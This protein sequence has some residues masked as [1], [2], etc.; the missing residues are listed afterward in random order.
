MAESSSR[1][2]KVDR[3]AFDDFLRDTLRPKEA[4]FYDSC[5]LEKDGL[6]YRLP[7]E[8]PEFAGLHVLRAGL[9]LGSFKKGRF[10]PSHALALALREHQ[11]IRTVNLSADSREAAAYLRGEALASET[12]DGWCL[13]LA[14][15]YS[16]GWGKAV[17][18]VV[19]NHYPKG[20]RRG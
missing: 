18:G 1:I 17:G 7:G 5:L 11:A 12:G 20:L 3:E 14:D 8:C 16:L 10:E 9:F 2:R 4:Y 13:V 6:L 19:K 15:G